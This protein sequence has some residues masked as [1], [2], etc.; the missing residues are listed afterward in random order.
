MKIHADRILFQDEHLLAVNKLS[1]ELVVKGAGRIDRLPLLDF[2]KQEYPGIR[3]LNRLDFET[4]GIVL[5]ARTK[6]MFDVMEEQYK[7][8]EMK[9]VYR[10]LVVGWL[11]KTKGTI[12]SKLPSR[13]TK[14]PVEATTRYSVIERLP[15][16]TYVEADMDSGRHHQIR[17]HFANIKHP[18]V[19]DDVYGDAK[20]NKLFFRQFK[21]ERFFLHA[22]S[23]SFVHP[24]T[25][26]TIHITAPLPRHF[27]DVLKK[28]KAL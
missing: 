9:K 17:R 22:A 16:V 3:P 4:S 8:H 14:E 6:H 2:L 1:G 18:L 21:Y 20:F 19:M 15:L 10:A 23:L 27:L 26:E 28:L 25:K 7:A 11:P 24:F 13:I 5:F 12:D